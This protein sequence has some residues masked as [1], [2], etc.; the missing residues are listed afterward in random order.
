MC[1][2]NLDEDPALA[3]GFGHVAVVSN[4]DL[5]NFRAAG[6]RTQNAGKRALEQT[7]PDLFQQET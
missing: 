2:M 1:Q 4:F 6:V 5:K 7:H 3:T